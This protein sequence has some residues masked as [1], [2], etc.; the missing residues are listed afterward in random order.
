MISGFI[1]MMM[2]VIEYL[3]VLSR[4]SWQ[5][6]LRESWWGQYLTAALLG[7]I[8]G[9]LGAFTVVSLYSHRV[10]SLG[11]LVTAMI[12]TSGD[13]TFFMLAVIPKTFVWLTLI[14]F[15][16]SLL[17]GWFTDRFLKKPGRRLDVPCEGLILHDE[18]QCVC[19]A[20]QSWLRQLKNSTPLR[21]VLV[22]A[23]ALILLSLIFGLIGPQRWN[24]VRITLI[25]V[26]VTGLFI[27]LTVPE[28]FLEEHLW[29]HVVRQ[30][31]PRI[32]LWTF[33]TLLV[34]M[35][36]E[37]HLDVGA[38]VQR[39]RFIVLIVA[40]LIGLIPESGPH[41]AFITLFSQG[42]LPFSV[43]LANSAVQ[44]GHGMLPLL[45]KSRK[46]FFAVKGVNLLVGLLLGFAGYWMG[47]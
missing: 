40:L 11:A 47:W 24:W 22:T 42:M 19:F 36:L 38:W 46:E 43:L 35:L 41:M 27:V 31:L 39:S 4:G 6:K 5:C 37:Q 18:E 14:L 21:G 20:P 44:D 1:F 33:G 45:A 23:L 17:A 12:A 32:F 30:H 10:V 2:L 13:E 25:T 29:K 15:P 9:C 28:H 3:N 7:T 8:P 34:L 16:V 26:S